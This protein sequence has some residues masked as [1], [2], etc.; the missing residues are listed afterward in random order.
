M[1]SNSVIVSLGF[2]CCLLLF[3]DNNLEWM[4]FPVLLFYFNVRHCQYDRFVLLENIEL[5]DCIVNSEYNCYN[6][7]SVFNT[8]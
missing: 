4:S 8:Y 6:V 5:F 2:K 7:V 1:Q 3:I